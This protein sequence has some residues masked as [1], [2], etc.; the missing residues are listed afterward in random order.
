[1][2][3]AAM[4]IRFCPGTVFLLGAGFCED[5]LAGLASRLFRANSLTSNIDKLKF[6]GQTRMQLP[7][8]NRTDNMIAPFK[9]D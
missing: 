2:V 7:S 5:C 3:L 9:F 1:M 8:M 4:M 6:I